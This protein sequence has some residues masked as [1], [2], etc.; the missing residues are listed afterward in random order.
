MKHTRFL[1]FSKLLSRRILMVNVATISVIALLIIAFATVGLKTM[2]NAYFISGLYA[3]HESISKRLGEVP[4]DSLYRHIRKMDIGMNAFNP[5]FNDDINEK[6]D[7]DVWA[8]NVVI[9]SVGNYIY[10]PDRQRIGK[11]CFFDDIRQSGEALCQKLALGL[12]SGT[13][14]KS[15][16]CAIPLPTCSS[17]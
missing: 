1:S 3:S 6:D 13:T 15:V 14:T 4:D 8:Y 10:R 9:D 11:A 17:R 7:K 2:T 16:R 12:Y 5:L